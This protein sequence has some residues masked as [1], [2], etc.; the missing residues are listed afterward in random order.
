[1][2]AVPDQVARWVPRRYV[3]LGTDGFGRSDTR[4]ALRRFFE[5]NAES[6]VVAT[7]AALADGDHAHLDPGDRPVEFADHFLHR[8]RDLDRIRFR[9]ADDVQLDHVAPVDE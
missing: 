3:S 7:L 2:T 8:A 9:L 6:V 4:E 1:M 5:T